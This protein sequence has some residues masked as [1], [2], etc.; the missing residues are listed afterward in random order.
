M[1]S[2]LYSTTCF[3]KAD[4]YRL[5]IYVDNQSTLEESVP[6]ATGSLD[7]TA[8]D[9]PIACIK[10]S[11]TRLHLQSLE[12]KRTIRNIPETITLNHLLNIKQTTSSPRKIHKSF[13]QSLQA[14]TSINASSERTTPSLEQSQ[15][16]TRVTLSSNNS[17]MK[18]KRGQFSFRRLFPSLST[19]DSEAVLLFKTTIKIDYV[20]VSNSIRW[21]TKTLELELETEELANELYANL[22]LCL[23]TL[24]Q[25]PR[26]LLAF[27]NPLSGKGHARVVYDKKV[28]PIFQQAN[29]AVQ[30][31]YTDRANHAQDHIINE[32]LDEYDGL[33]CAGGDG[34]FAELC[35]GLL[36]RTARDREINIDDPQVDI[37]RPNLR[38]GIIPAGSTDAVVFGTTGLNDPVT[39]ALQIIAGESLPIDITTVHN[40]SGFVRFMATMLAYGFFGDIIHQSDRWRCL[41]PLRYDLAGFCQFVRN[42]SYHSELTITLSPHDSAR[43]GHPQAATSLSSVGGTSSVAPDYQRL[44]N[45]S[46]LSLIDECSKNKSMDTISKIVTPNVTFCSRNCVLCAEEKADPGKVHSSLQIKREGRYTTVNCLNM[47]CRCAKS[48]YGMSPFVHLGDGTFDLILVKRSWRT[49][50]LRFLWQVANDSR[51]IEDLPNVEK[52]RVSEVLIRPINTG[53]KR[54]GNWSCD[55]ELINGNEIQVRVHRQALNLFASGIQFAEHQKAENLKKPANIWFPCFRTKKNIKYEESNS[56]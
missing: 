2:I 43:I 49:G 25:R 37:I 14:T 50:F 40:E 28:L 35:H 26:R 42:T 36:L 19:Q 53:R 9:I 46:S 10:P 11:F 4:L 7:F 52:Y 29:I 48:K 20:D 23:S 18:F 15:D 6:S 31:I 5:R 33:I 8:T 55:G 1:P 34:M 54:G 24:T 12:D 16:S 17:E 47:P 41:G 45:S 27:V 30:T 56:F 39:S 13:S 32:P 44:I 21:N 3:I 51:T 22:N 38:I